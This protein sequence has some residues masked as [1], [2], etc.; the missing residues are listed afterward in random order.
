MSHSEVKLLGEDAPLSGDELA[1]YVVINESKNSFDF[2]EEAI[3]KSFTISTRPKYGSEGKEEQLTKS[4]DVTI[5]D[6]YNIYKPYELNYVTNSTSFDFAA[7]DASEKRGQKDM[8]K[9]F[10]KNE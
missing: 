7:V 5:V 4:L 1:K 9:D 6:G 3:G 2:T 10:L 8:V